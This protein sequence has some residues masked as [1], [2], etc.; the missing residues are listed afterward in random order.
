M[1]PCAM[2][3][4]DQIAKALAWIGAH[5]SIR[6]VLITGGDPLAMTD[7]QIGTIMA[8]VAKFPHVGVI[9]IGTR[10]PATLPMRLTPELVAL[11]GSFRQP[12]R[13]EVC[14]VTHL[15]HPY[16]ITP[17]LVDAIERVRRQ[18]ISVYNQLVFTFHVSRRFEAARLR[19]LLRR[20]G[21]DPYYTFVPK[22]KEET[23]SYRVPIARL[24][25]E[26]KEEAR[27]LPGLCRTDEPVYNLPALG[28]NHIRAVQDRDLIGLHPDGSRVYEFHPW[29]KNILDRGSYI[30]RDI[31]ILEYLE[32]LAAIGEDPADYAGI[33]YYY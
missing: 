30:G 31:P 3:S 2:A 14:L 10:V 22:G 1:D 27:L 12:G 25:Q 32:R 20:I 21:I 8:G 9:R 17:E 15:Q 26:R 24:L 5:P 23:L 18:G 11:L 33:W 28:K 7:D 13:R 6:E 19:L 29:E 4:P 16:E